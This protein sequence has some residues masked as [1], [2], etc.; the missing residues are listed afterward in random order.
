MRVGRGCAAPPPLT[1]CL[2]RDASRGKTSARGRKASHLGRIKRQVRWGPVTEFIVQVILP[3]LA[4]PRPARLLVALVLAHEVVAR[5][6]QA[7]TDGKRV[8]KQHEKA[9]V[10]HI[11]ALTPLA[12]TFHPALCVL[13]CFLISAKTTSRSTA[14]AQGRHRLCILHRPPLERSRNSS[15]TRGASHA[16]GAST[17]RRMAPRSRQWRASVDASRSRSGGRRCAMRCVLRPCS[18]HPRGPCRRPQPV[19]VAARATAV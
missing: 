8:H 7:Q 2:R 16:W 3:L 9:Q 5:A 11:L 1:S 12:R 10:L 17:W 6:G 15:Y 13:V 18:Q 19:L 14:D 4:C